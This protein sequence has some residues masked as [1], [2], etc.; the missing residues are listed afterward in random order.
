MS[1]MCQVTI[2]GRLTAEP[3][4]KVP[5]SGNSYTRLRL[6]WNHRK[7]EPGYI[8][9]TLFGK[10]GETAATYL[11][12]GSQVCLAG[13]RLEWRQYE[14]DGEKR[15]A[16]SLVGGDLIMLGKK[17]DAQNTSPTLKNDGASQGVASDDDI[18]F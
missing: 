1:S 6:A 13:S 5:A 18:P 2:I 9:A 11:H 3:E 16:Y 7:D 4:Q 14:K 8:D 17:D 10:T 15:T 12:K